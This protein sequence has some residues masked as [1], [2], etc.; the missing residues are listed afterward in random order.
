MGVSNI[1][2]NR[3]TSD[4]K[5]KVAWILV[6]TSLLFALISAS[7]WLY[8][9]IFSN[10]TPLAAHPRQHV[11]HRPT[12]TKSSD[13]D[14]AM[15]SATV[16]QFMHAYLAQDYQ[17]T[18]SMLHPQV[19]AMWP[20][21]KIY[22]TFSKARFHDYTLQG[23]SQGKTWNRA[24]WTNPETMMRYI[25]V[26][27]QA[28]SLQL[29]PT[30]AIAKGSRLAPEVQ[31]PEPLFQNLPFIIQA[32]PGKDGQQKQWLV[33]SAGPANPEAPILPPIVPVSRT[34]QV[35]ILMYHH[36]SNM[37]TYNLIDFSLT[38]TPGAF[39][40]QLEYLKAHKYHSITFNQLFNA[41]Y[42]EAPLPSRPI[43]L[44]FDDGYE[45]G[46]QFAYPLLKRYGF[47]G[48]FYIITGKV[49]W[50][51]QMSWS[52]MREMIA[53]GMQMGSHTI[54][55]VDIGQVLLNSPAQA[56]QEL[57]VSQNLMQQHLG[58]AIQQFCYP[59]GEPFRHGSLS[60]QQAV[61]ALVTASG[62][63]GATN[64][65]GMIGPMQSSLSPLVLLR[66]RVDGRESLAGFT[67][68]LPW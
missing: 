34:V 44:T 54:H 4:S 2:M 38:V 10:A 36:I 66:T 21:E 52:Q 31:R 29:K 28:V 15:V 35:P 59:S 46:Y 37:P 25:N 5:K 1:G 39:Q 58:I 40:K 24:F 19:Q 63:V 16:E 43:I 68:S 45:D 57:Q 30:Q 3:R 26:E 6:A 48:M 17:T 47:S 33:L 62:Y 14:A 27:V 65:P 7:L 23:F 53:N 13:Q 55:H 8:M 41:L 18:W 49:G 20:S 61:I 60:L 51:G 12:V 50:Q 67:Q 11:H 64:D 32:V 22:A 9:A 56:A 42:F